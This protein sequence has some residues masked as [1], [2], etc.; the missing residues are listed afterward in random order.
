VTWR[1]TFL[2]LLAGIVAAVLLLV[3]LRTRTRPADA[4]LLGIVPAETTGLEI[5]GGGS[6]TLL[7]NRDGVWWITLPLTDRADP[8]MVSR[9]LVPPPMPSRSTG[10]GPPTSRGCPDSTRSTSGRRS[11]R[12]R[13]GRKGITYP[14]HRRG[15]RRPRPRLRTGRFGSLGLPDLLGDGRHRLPTDPGT[16]RSL[17][18]AGQARENLGNR[19]S[20]A[21]GIQGTGAG[22]ERP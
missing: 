9:L 13:S 11:A 16:A 3:T 20:A 1:G 15:R 18:L 7:E 6:T 10:C 5:A 14:S 4:P 22:Q 12:S 17:P 21:G 8:T 19:A 2:L